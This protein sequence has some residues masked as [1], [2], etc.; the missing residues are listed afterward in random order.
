MILFAHEYTKE[1]CM[2]W[3]NGAELAAY[4]GKY[5]MVIII[6]NFMLK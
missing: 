4:D 1:I 3:K 5:C 2:C 6:T